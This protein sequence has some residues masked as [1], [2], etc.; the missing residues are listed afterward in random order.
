M[1]WL[2]KALAKIKKNFGKKDAGCAKEKCPLKETGLLVVLLRKENRKP[3][4]K[5][6]VLIKGKTNSNRKTDKDGIAL[7]KPVDPDTYEVD[8][9]LPRDM[10]NDYEKP[11]A[12]NQSVSLGACPIK[13]IHVEAMATLKVHVYQKGEP[14]KVFGGAT[15]EVSGAQS[16]SPKKTQNADGKIDFGKTKAGKYTIKTTLKEADKKSFG[17]IQSPKEVVLQSGK[18][19]T[20][21]I[22]VAPMNVV[23][24]KIEME[25]KVVLLDPKLPDPNKDKILTSPTYIIPSVDQKDTTNPYQKT[26]KLKCSA[27]KV[28]AY[29]DEECKKKLAGDLGL[30]ITL[31]NAQLTDAQ[32]TKS[33]LKGKA[34]GQFEV[35]LELEDPADGSQKVEKPVE[36]KG[37]EKMGVVKLEMVLHQQDTT[38]IKKLEIDP[39]IDPPALTAPDT[40]D[41]KPEKYHPNLMKQYHKS[42]KDK[43][44]PDQKALTNEEKVK[45]GRVLHLQK[46]NT[47]GRAKLICKKLDSAQWPAGTDDY[48]ITIKQ[49]RDSGGLEVYDKEWE[50][51]KKTLPGKIKLADLKAGDQTFWVQGSHTTKKLRDV[52]LDLGIDR[53]EK[54]LEKKPKRNGDWANFT[55]VQIKEVKVDYKAEAGKAEAW[56]E[57]NGRF[58][59]NLG[60][61]WDDANKK[62]TMDAN[63]D[64]NGRKITVGAKL[65]EELKDVTVHFMLAPDKDNCTTAN[66]GIDLPKKATIPKGPIV[67]SIVNQDDHTKFSIGGGGNDE[68]ILEDGILKHSTKDDYKVTY[69]ATDGDGNTYDSVMKFSVQKDSLEDWNTTGGKSIKKLEFDPTSV[70]LW[71][72]NKI[73]HSVKHKDKENRKHLLHFSA[74]T[75]AKG[76]AK[77]EVILSRFGGDKY[78]P[79]CYIDQDPHL[80]KYVHGHTDLEK[81]KPIFAAKIINVWRKIW[82][83]RVIV[84]DIDCPS[85]SPAENKYKLI[86]VEMVDAGD[87]NLA[88][89]TVN[90]YTPKAIYKKHMIKVTG[91]NT[92]ALVVSDKNKKQFFS[93]FAQEKDKPNKIPLVVCDA[94]WDPHPD[95]GGNS[96]SKSPPPLDKDK[97]PFPLDVGKEVLNTPLQGGTLFDSGTWTS[98][99]KNPAVAGGWDNIKNGNLSNADISINAGRVSLK[100]V[101]VAIPA[102]VGAPNAKTRIWLKNVVVKAAKSYLGESF[103]HEITE[104]G[105]GT[106]KEQRIL[107]VYNPAEAADFQ[108]T[109]VHEFG[110]AY[111]QVIE[112]NPA[113]GVAGVHSHPNQ[114]NA[115]NQG[116]HCRHLGN[117]CV[118]FDSGPIFQS[119]NQYCDICHMYMLVQDMSKVSV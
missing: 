19:T 31:T 5:A 83:Q 119:L 62:F 91:G 109:V 42:L 15:I 33:Y 14:T 56:K 63:T 116:N 9:T 93:G 88:K 61:T 47:F 76:Y 65:S 118:M 6:P 103:P 25:Y 82:Y 34:A 40:Y 98:A 1:S 48:E 49:K 78:Q 112:G 85:F 67:W 115:N 39:D 22:E 55:V 106:H 16:H 32:K 17:V 114:K 66:W 29:L 79:A 51:A 28:E 54:G 99:E 59:V 58:Y 27:A 71:K 11:K 87:L 69:R 72:W 18:E 94:Q 57:S 108:N 77:K 37:K 80:A 3:I 92:D 12:E 10:S 24:P 36:A 89:A 86:Y 97:F 13:V 110:H 52:R 81:K 50:G 84:E 38:E 44:I 53:P 90:A 107:S 46:D 7:F 96:Q 70:K 23:T 21:P 68:L 73:S 60:A 8:V 104:P 113:G 100:H 45:N 43:A 4:E 117:K 101:H 111:H 26:G 74:K 64:I 30:G 20:I 105:G 75:D 35:S 102:G 95:D 41:T 2:S